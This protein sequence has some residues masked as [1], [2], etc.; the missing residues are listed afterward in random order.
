MASSLNDDQSSVLS[1][2]ASN[3]TEPSS[4][5]HTAADS[6]SHDTTCKRAADDVDNPDDTYQG[7]NWSKLDG[8][9]KAPYSRRQHTSWTWKYGYR[10]QDI[11]TQVIFWLCKLCV[12]MKAHKNTMYNMAG[13]SHSQIRHLRGKHNLDAN[14]PIQKKRR[15]NFD[16]MTSKAG[17]IEQALINQ[18]I[19]DFNPERFKTA[20]LRWMAYANISFRQN[21]MSFYKRR[22]P[23]LE[24]LAVYQRLIR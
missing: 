13:G 4:F 20:L 14:G 23:R 12:Q 9:A 18:R 11:N 2:A 17:T 5:L 22:M 1:T 15:L 7:I 21:F 16:G 19:S 8:Y 6:Q 10:I 3:P 24:Q